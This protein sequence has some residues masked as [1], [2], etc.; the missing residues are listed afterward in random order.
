MLLVSHPDPRYWASTLI[1]NAVG[2]VG[3]QLLIAAHLLWSTTLS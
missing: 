2:S 1:L 3:G